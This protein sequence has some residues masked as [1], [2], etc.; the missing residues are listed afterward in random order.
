MTTIIMKKTT[1]SISEQTKDQLSK[2]GSKGES[3]D[4]IL[5]K[6]MADATTLCNKT[7]EDD[8]VATT[9]PS[10]EE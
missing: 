1:V 6:V 10:E 9:E 8:D 3:F 5:N 4:Q 2:F 7:S